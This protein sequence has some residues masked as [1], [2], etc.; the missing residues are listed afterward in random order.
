M[1]KG[2]KKGM[3]W[4]ECGARPGSSV[5]PAITLEA[6]V[7]IEPTG[8]TTALLP[9]SRRTRYRPGLVPRGDV[10]RHNGKVH[11]YPL[12][13]SDGC[14]LRGAESLLTGGFNFD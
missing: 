9:L 11:I 7:G 2:N 1:A 12:K 8:A 14:A 4:G 13:C 3:E 5:Q 10:R 6:R